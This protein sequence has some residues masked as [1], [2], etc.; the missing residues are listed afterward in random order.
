MLLAKLVSTSK[1][2]IKSYWLTHFEHQIV[3]E[4]DEY[5]N[6]ERFCDTLLTTELLP[7]SADTTWRDLKL[8]RKEVLA[9]DVLL[10]ALRV[11]LCYLNK[12]L[13]T[14]M[15]YHYI[16]LILNNCVNSKIII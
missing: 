2:N 16:S 11:L 8:R 6:R 1:Q 4:K 15:R 9:L 7:P 12:F 5:N 3:H 13:E 14:L 10:V